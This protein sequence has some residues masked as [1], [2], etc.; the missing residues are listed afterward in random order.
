MGL[1]SQLFGGTKKPET[2]ANL[3][4]PGTYSLDIVG[5]SK[6]Q[7]TLEKICGG[8]TEEGHEKIVQATLI[9]ED[10]NPYDNKAIRVDIDG[11]T[12]GYL[13]RENAREYRTRLKEAGHPG[14]TATCSAIIVGGWDRGA[15]DRGHFGVKLDL[16]T[17]E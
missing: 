1:F 17:D 16:P 3:P 9:H 14:I 15:R 4:G 10:D 7:S 12:V 11:M 13:S 5:E 2:I 6:Y 8:R